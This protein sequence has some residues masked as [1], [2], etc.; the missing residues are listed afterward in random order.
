[1]CGYIKT[2]FYNICAG[3]A[4]RRRGRRKTKPRP[5]SPGGGHLPLKL[6]GREQETSLLEEVI[7]SLLGDSVD[8]KG[9]LQHPPS[10]P[11]KIV[12]PRGVGKTALLTWTK[13]RAEKNEKVLV[14][15][16]AYLDD[17]DKT[18]DPMDSLVNAMKK[19]PAKVFDTL[20]AAGVSLPGGFGLNFQTDRPA[21][22]Y[23]HL[24]AKIVEAKPLLLLLDEVHH[25]DLR[26]LGKLLQ[27]NQQLISDGYPLGMVLAGTPGLDSHLAK[28]SSTFISRCDQIH[29]NTLSDAATREA[30]EEPLRQVGVTVA[31]DALE[32]M[33]AQTDNYP[34]FIQ[35]VGREVWRAASKAGRK[36]V[37][38]ALVKQVEEQARKGR[39]TIYTQA[40]DRMKKNRLLPYARQVMELLERN[41]GKVHED[42]VTDALVAANDGVDEDRAE[43]IYENLREDGFIWTVD[44]ETAPGIPSFFSYFKDRQKQ[45]KNPP[46]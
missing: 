35:Y 14:V 29:I 43:E 16:C 13:R 40:Y 12:G 4:N 6:A 34:Y 7:E 23:E 8:G 18:G 9:Y 37:D 42:A 41:G 36:D 3:N 30:L 39:R 11:I 45:P 27:V 2:E 10:D 31:P 5:F 26:P 15:R 28:A 22:T 20:K 44:D 24:I 21:D 38:I 19:W 25:F 46:T 1:M 33:A 17:D 32:A